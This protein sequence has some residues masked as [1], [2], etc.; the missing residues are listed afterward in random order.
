MSPAIQP[1]LPIGYWLKHADEVITK[2]INQV[3]AANG[4]SRFQ[5]QLLNSIH[6]VGTV[7]KAQLFGIMQT[8]VSH[9]DF[10]KM[11]DEMIDK[12]WLS[13]DEKNEGLLQLTEEG[14]SK[15]QIIL[16]SQKE[17]RQRTVQGVSEEEYTTVISVLQRIVENLEGKHS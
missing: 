17:V 6:E 16:E 13:Q 3:Q 10:E 9:A 5:W 14:N 2:H 4:V 1:N 7:S 15:H 12:G 11:I 8:F